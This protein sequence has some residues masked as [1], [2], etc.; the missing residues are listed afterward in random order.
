MATVD[1]G[2]RVDDTE[3]D[4]DEDQ[5]VS[6]Y[7]DLLTRTRVC[8]LRTAT[9]FTPDVPTAT[10]KV[11]LSIHFFKPSKTLHYSTLRCISVNQACSN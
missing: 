7:D 10:R 5:S 9:L 6:S 1:S 11:R 2:D 8:L 4:S 3:V